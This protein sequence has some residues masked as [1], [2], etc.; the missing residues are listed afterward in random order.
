MIKTRYVPGELVSGNFHQ[1]REDPLGFLVAAQAEFGPVFK[2]R[3]YSKRTTV[4]CGQECLKVLSTDAAQKLNRKKIFSPFAHQVGLDIFAAD[5]SS[6]EA[7]S[8]LLRVPYGRDL[9]EAF[10]PEFCAVIAQTLGALEERAV[11]LFSLTKKL[12]L[13]LAMRMITPLPL[14]DFA[15]DFSYAGGEV[16]SVQ[17]GLKKRYHFFK[18]QYKLAHRRIGRVID[19]LIDRHRRQGPHTGK[20]HLIDACIAAEL[21]DGTRMND[22][23][24]RGTCFY[25][26]AGSEIY[27]GRLAGFL[28][29]EIL[30]N[31]ELRR[32][33]EVEIED[34]DLS[35]DQE[36]SFSSDR[37]PVLYA[38]FRETLR[39]YPLLPGLP[40]NAAADLLISNHLI[41]KGS[42]L[43]FA[44]HLSNFQEENYPEARTFNHQRYLQDGKMTG[45]DP[46]MLSY[47]VGKKVC[48]AQG[49][50]EIL[51]LTIVVCLLQQ[52]TMALNQYEGPLKLRLN[53]LIEPTSPVIISIG[54]LSSL[55]ASALVSL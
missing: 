22:R 6:H 55:A 30:K 34:I 52:K 31:E 41:K 4:I 32:Q 20:R 28:L 10:V 49:M 3:F 5:R 45:V 42:R 44:P 27:I 1:L 48:K 12:S 40:Y 21:P 7:L 24:I 8:G 51:T 19:G 18:P 37:T 2:L 54:K 15:A 26:I 17:F 53:P 39:L 29:F 46:K 9:A 35:A 13:Q 25:A 14:E 43:L 11:D 36:Q 23:A 50:N 33:I 47:G 16:M 38:A